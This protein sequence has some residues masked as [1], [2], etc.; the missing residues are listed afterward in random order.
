MMIAP[1][2]TVKTN[3]EGK[4][5]CMGTTLEF[6]SAEPDRFVKIIASDEEDA[7]EQLQMYLRADFSLHLLVSDM[8][9]LCRV[10]RA[11]GLNVPH[12]FAELLGEKLWSEEG[13]SVFITRVSST[14]APAIANISNETTERIAAKWV[15]SYT[16][17]PEINLDEYTRSYDYAFRA[18]SELRTISQ[19]ALQ[20]GRAL[21]LYCAGIE[22]MLPGW[23]HT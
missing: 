5:D 9:T 15:R 11:Q 6:Y 4:G 14:L 8:D 7:L 10:M 22:M 23:L 3:G 1:F 19:D 21:L 2:N 16:V 18:L 17:D 13:G 20:R 12:S